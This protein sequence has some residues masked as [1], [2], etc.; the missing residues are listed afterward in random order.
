MFGLIERNILPAIQ[1]LVDLRNGFYEKDEE[2]LRT[3]LESI[4]EAMDLILEFAAN[5]I[6]QHNYRETD[7]VSRN[8][9]QANRMADRYW[10]VFRRR[11]GSDVWEKHNTP[12]F[13]SWFQA[14]MA[15]EYLNSDSD[16]YYFAPMTL[17]RARELGWR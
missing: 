3:T 11:G 2:D 7:E 14:D 17:R 6:K 13:I 16:E 4:D 1:L 5:H 15:A 12:S 9:V 10:F 8:L